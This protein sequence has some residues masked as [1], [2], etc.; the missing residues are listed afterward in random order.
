MAKI[1][2]PASEQHHPLKDPFLKKKLEIV[3]ITKLKTKEA[4]TEYKIGTIT[5]FSVSITLI[6][7]NESDKTNTTM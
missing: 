2:A 6:K 4:T 5:F 3:P 1:R 7:S